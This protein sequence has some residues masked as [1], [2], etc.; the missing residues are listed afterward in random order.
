MKLS[1][2]DAWLRGMLLT[3]TIGAYPVW[4]ALSRGAPILSVWA[5][6]AVVS[7]VAGFVFWLGSRLRRQ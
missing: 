5:A 6:V 7:V 1:W 2:T 4:N 3:L